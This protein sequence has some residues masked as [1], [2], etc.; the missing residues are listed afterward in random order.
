[1]LK[2]ESVKFVTIEKKMKQLYETMFSISK[3]SIEN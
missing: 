1:M 2:F 3:F